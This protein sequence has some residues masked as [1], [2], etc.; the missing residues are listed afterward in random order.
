[1]ALVSSSCRRLSAI[2]EAASAQRLPWLRLLRQRLS[3][4]PRPWPSPRPAAHPLRWPRWG[5][6]SD[7]TRSISPFLRSSSSPPNGR[8]CQLELRVHFDRFKRANFNA[9]LAAH[10]DGDIDV[11]AR[12][13][14]LRL[15]HVVRLLVFALVDVDALG[16]AFFL[17]D[18]AGHAAQAGLPVGAVVDKKG[19]YARVLDGGNP[20]FRILD[21][22]QPFFGDIAAGEILRRL[23]HPFRC[24]H[25]AMHPPTSVPSVHR[26]PCLPRLCNEMRCCSPSSL[27]YRSTSPSTISTLPKISTTSATFWPR[28]MSSRTVRLIRLGGR[29]R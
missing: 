24:L 8:R 16:R 12:R 5:G 11:E 29:T 10:A 19:K 17:A 13:I 4:W 27:L 23:R 22:R 21:R 28:H 9:D 1:M 18:L 7:S 14:K 26:G 25:R 15:A 20:L 3:P 2:G 6:S